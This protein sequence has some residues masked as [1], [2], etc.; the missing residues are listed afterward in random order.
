MASIVVLNLRLHTENSLML[1]RFSGFGVRS[2]VYRALRKAGLF[3]EDVH[4]VPGI[5]RFRV[6]PLYR[7]VNGSIIPVYKYV[8]GNECIHVDI[9]LF[10]DSYNEPKL[11]NLIED[12]DVF[13][14]DMHKLVISNA[15][16]RILN[17]E[18]LYFKP[19]RYIYTF[20]I[21]PT[22][23]RASPY[24]TVQMS[25][26][27]CVCYQRRSRRTITIPYPYPELLVRNLMRLYREYVAPIDESIRIDVIR[28]VCEG[29][30]EV[31]RIINGV[32]K[33]V[34]YS[35]ERHTGFT[36]EVY[37]RLND[38]EGVDFNHSLDEIKSLIMRLFKLADYTGVGG[39]RTLGLGWVRSEVV[40]S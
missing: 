20:F 36:G 7:V 39:G 37:Y 2:T 10:L 14:I 21:T 27:S 11:Y 29:G 38:I 3:E 4:N 9:S 16:I 30:L 26:G 13:E 24:Y 5:R 28:Y 12:L 33:T 40:T 22:F 32:I 19:S 18:Y 23:F 8:R 6:T 25:D 35:R 1:N 34:K 15:E 31:S 17:P